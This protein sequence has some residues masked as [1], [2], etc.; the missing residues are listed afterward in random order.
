LAGR[1]PLPLSAA[2]PDELTENQRQN[3]ER[4]RTEIDQLT[5][6]TIHG[7]CQRLITPYPVEANIDPGA[8]VVD[9]D[10]GG[11]LFNDLFDD[12]LRGRLATT[13]TED[14]LFVELILNDPDATMELV[15]GVAL[16]L[17]RNRSTGAPPAPLPRDPTAR[18]NEA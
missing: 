10:E 11:L 12:W 6:S 3:L 13:P 4:A 5:C 9:P 15:R 16:F 1:T 18:L 17:R 14:D 2:I 8:R 7:F